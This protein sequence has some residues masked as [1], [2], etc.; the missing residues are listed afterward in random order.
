M[1]GLGLVQGRKL[2]MS[3][4]LIE[5]QV[6]FTKLLHTVQETNLKFSMNDSSKDAP[7]SK[8]KLPSLHALLLRR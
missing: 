6:F 8:R 5:G 7:F 2:L 3:I 4:I 1:L